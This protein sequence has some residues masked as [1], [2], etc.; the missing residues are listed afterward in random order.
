MNNEIIEG[1]T[2]I[3]NLSIVEGKVS[4]LLKVAKIIPVYKN[5]DTYSPSNYRPI[6]LLSIFDKILEKTIYLRLKQVLDKHNI[7]FKNINFGFRE[8]QSPSHALIDLVEYIYK[9]LDE[10][11][12]VFGIYIDLKKAFDKV[13]HDILLSKLQHY[14][15][16]GNEVLKLTDIHKYN[17]I[18]LMCKLMHYPNKIPGAVK[19]SLLSILR[20]IAT[21]QEINMTYMQHI[22]IPKPMDAGNSPSYADK[23]GILFHR[24][25]K[26][27]IFWQIQSIP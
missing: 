11:K 7:L 20:S 1:L 16:W 22:S 15:I 27:E 9:S 6:P 19:S 18:I 5:G 14:G 4:D 24:P 2:I 23:T 13:S 8:N 21:T 26:T 17:L 25:Q 3:I 10:N 12:F